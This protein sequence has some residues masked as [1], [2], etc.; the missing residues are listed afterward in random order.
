MSAP[1]TIDLDLLLAPIAG[2]KPTGTD[3]RENASPASPYFRVKDARASARAFERSNV[4]PDAPVAESWSVV[5]DAGQKLLAKDAKDL[6]IAAWMTEAL[7]RIEGFAGLRDGLRLM[8][9]LATAFWDDL[10][11]MPDEEG[12]ETR[13]APVTGLNGSGAPGTLAQPL[14]TL[15][16]VGIERSFSLWTYDQML[17]ADKLADPARKAARLAAGTPSIEAFRDSLAET[18][19]LELQSTLST[20]E[21][22]RAALKELTTVFDEAA[23]YD[24]PPTTAL[25]ELLDCVAGSIRFFGADKLASIPAAA[26]AAAAA[27]VLAGAD[28]AAAQ[29]AGTAS[30]P[31]V[32]A[33]RG[34]VLSREDALSAVLELAEYFRRTE[35]Q[36]P[37]SYTLDEAVRRARMSLPDLLKELTLDAANTSRFL[38]AAGIRQ[39]NPPP[40]GAVAL[41]GAA[42]VTPDPAP[43][44]V[45][46]KPKSSDGW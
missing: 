31:V 12:M 2:E 37:I 23:G 16:I 17:E 1:T 6:E 44:P 3:P 4:D 41:P 11:P 38:M 20:V 34:Q 7:V 8:T 18:P 5:L 30:G 28:S 29:G 42:F 22:A 14:R 15:P 35:P 25:Q 46:P 33:A 21:E 26:P 24:A 13:V 45:Q 39:E 36:A 10:Y 9:G 19:A 32:P 40:P 27:P 43:A